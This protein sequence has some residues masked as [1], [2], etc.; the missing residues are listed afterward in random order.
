MERRFELRVEELLKDAELDPRIPDGMLDRLERFVEPY[1]AIM[2]SPA[3]QQH[4]WEYVAGLFSDVK[5]KSA[6]MIAYFHDQDRQALQKFIGQC[7]WDDGLL[8]AE[9]SR[10]VGAELPHEF[11]TGVG[12][13]FGQ[14][15]MVFGVG[16]GLADDVQGVLKWHLLVRF[17]AVKQRDGCAD[18]LEIQVADGIFEL[19]EKSRERWAVNVRLAGKQDGTLDGLIICEF[20]IGRDVGEFLDA[21]FEQAETFLAAAIER[22]DAGFRQE[23]PALV[24]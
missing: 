8:I 14:K 20:Y 5:R 19:A 18:G 17:D 7:L 24:V 13:S 22:E 4:L 21:A 16:T 6:E 1:V 3:Q 15:A 12:G 11:R 2:E 9:L 10:Q 23:R